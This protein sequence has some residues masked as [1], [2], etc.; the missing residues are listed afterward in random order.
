MIERDEEKQLRAH[1]SRNSRVCI[2]NV[3]IGC[4]H[5]ASFYESILTRAGPQENT[6][7]NLD[8]DRDRTLLRLYHNQ[9]VVVGNILDGSF[10][11]ASARNDAQSNECSHDIDFAVCKAIITVVV[12]I[13]SIYTR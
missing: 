3:F 10:E 4:F 8:F 9:V 11:Q 1:E 7:V 12:S 13:A 2:I 6:L 5:S